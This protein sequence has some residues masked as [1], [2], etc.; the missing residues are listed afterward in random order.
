MWIQ[1]PGSFECASCHCVGNFLK[2][3]QAEKL[4]VIDGEAAIWDRRGNRRETH[5]FRRCGS[6]PGS[7]ASRLLDGERQQFGARRRTAT[8]KGEL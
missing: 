1:M 7:R 8:D 4:D 2:M 3:S 6:A 5:R